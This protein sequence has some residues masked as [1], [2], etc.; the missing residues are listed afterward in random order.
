[1]DLHRRDAYVVAMAPAVVFLGVYAYERGRYYFLKVAPEFIDLSMNRLL[2]GGAV[3][4]ALAVT[5]VG[6]TL[7]MWK[8]SASGGRYQRLFAAFLALSVFVTLPMALWLQE[9]PPLP[10]STR[11]GT[12]FEDSLA[13]LSG[14]VASYTVSAGIDS[15]RRKLERAKRRLRKVKDAAH[16]SDDT[17]GH[18]VSVQAARAEDESVVNDDSTIRS[19]NP[20][21]DRS[22]GAFVASVVSW[23]SIGAIALLTWTALVFAGLGYRMERSY[24]TRVCVADRFVADVHGDSLL[25]KSFNPKTGEILSP[26]KVVEMNGVDLDNCSPRLI[27]ARG[28]V[29]WE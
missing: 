25:L 22:L 4:G 7:W 6:L 20:E 18:D 10:A 8:Y 26:I 3:I 12:L 15:V 29:L 5:L 19:E 28:L 23:K 17:H 2:A 16:R 1:M 14:M 13:I 27:G 21:A 24:G 9:L 11:F